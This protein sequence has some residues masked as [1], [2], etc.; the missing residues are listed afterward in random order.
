MKAHGIPMDGLST[1]AT[2]VLIADDEPEVVETLARVLREQTGYEV[3]TATSSFAA[4]VACER[5]RPNVILLDIHLDGGDG[6][7]VARLIR[8]TTS[9]QGVRLIGMSGKLT[10]GQAQSIRNL[11]YDSFLKKPFQIRSVIDAIEHAGRMAA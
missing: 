1:G 11:G 8:D 9:G 6:R 3:E 2:R 10:D 4:G 5:F 7:E